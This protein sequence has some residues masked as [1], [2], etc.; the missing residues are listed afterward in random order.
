MQ[1]ASLPYVDEH[2]TVIAAGTDEVWRSLGEA[3]DRSFSRPRA[4]G[5]ARLVGSAHCTASGPRP[6]AEDSTIPGFRVVAAVPGR[7]LVL[8]GSHRFSS[9]A[10]IFRLDEVGPAR[11]RLRAETRATFPGLASDLYRRLV[12]GTGG[13]AVGMR[14]LLSAIRRLSE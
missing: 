7:E 5:Y 1:I 3:L 6:L 9:Y 8:K 10:L 12:I 11:S 13:H 4:V 14:R 2:A